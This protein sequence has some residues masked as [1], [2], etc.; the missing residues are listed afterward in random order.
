MPRR[1]VSYG[2]QLRLIILIICVAYAGA[3]IL[4][5][6][7]AARHQI[8]E[9]FRD[10]PARFGGLIPSEGIKVCLLLNCLFSLNLLFPQ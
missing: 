1:F 7:A 4:V 3:D 9:E 5:F 8:E 6:S 2:N 10:A